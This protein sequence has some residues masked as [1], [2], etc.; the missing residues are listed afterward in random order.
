[1]YSIE[2]LKTSDGCPLFYRYP[3][4]ILAQPAFVQL[5][6]EGVV[7]AGYNSEIGNA[8]PADVWHKCVIRWDVAPEVRGMALARLLESDEVK[9]LIRVVRNGHS[10][11][12]KNGNRV[13][14]LDEEA[15]DA[16][17]EI[18]NLLD[19]LSDPSNEDA[20]DVWDASEYLFSSNELLQ[21]WASGPIPIAV[22]EINADAMSQDVCLDGDV[23]E[24]LL[25][26]AH[27]YVKK[28]ID[29]LTA[30]HLDELVRHKYI[31]QA[32]AD[33]YACSFLD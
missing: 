29:G 9:E 16:R 20:A 5:D 31:M 10:T 33:E 1:M 14:H 15:S 25:E 11:E 23:S 26:E 8:V 28:E 32:E 24:C 4:Q 3:S 18:Q 6:E 21:V 22:A 2:D 17:D 7:T 12:Y 27:R 13:G 30:D 19:E